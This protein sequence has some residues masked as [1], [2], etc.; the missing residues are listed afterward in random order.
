MR[1][2]INNIIHTRPRRHRP[3]KVLYWN[4]DGNDYAHDPPDEIV[5][6]KAGQT[7]ADPKYI[8]PC[9]C[10]YCCYY[11]MIQDGKAKYLVLGPPVPM[12][13]AGREMAEIEYLV[14]IKQE[15]CVRV[16]N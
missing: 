12:R 10:C 15:D 3:G 16:I 5:V 14:P 6:Y 1:I 9:Y 8:A 11:D 4:S 13:R 7:M 2:I